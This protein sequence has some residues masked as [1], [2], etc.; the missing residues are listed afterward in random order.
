MLNRNFKI[1]S[2]LINH[3]ADVDALWKP[4]SP[5]SP[6]EEH[7]DVNMLFEYLTSNLDTALVPLRYLLEPLHS[8][9]SVLSFIVVPGEKK[10][11][12]HL[13]CRHGN[14]LIVDYLLKKFNT[15]YHLDFVDCGGF[16]ALH[17]AVFNGH[18]DVARKLYR[19]DTRVDILAGDA[20]L[21]PRG[22]RNALDYCHIL[23]AP[24]ASSLRAS[25]GIIR[26]LE[27]VYLGRLDIAKMLVRERQA[28][29]TV[30]SRDDDGMVWSVKLC[31]YAAQKNMARLLKGSLEN[32]R[33]DV[34][35]SMSR[36]E[37]LD[38]LLVDAALSGHA[39]TTK[40]LVD[41]GANVNQVLPVDRQPTLLHQ[42]VVQADAKM[43]YLLRAGAEVNA[44]DKKGRTPL[45]YA[46]QWKDL[47]TCR[48]LKH[49]GGETT[50]ERNSM[51]RILA[52]IVGTDIG[53][54][55]SLV[56]EQNLHWDV[57]LGGEPSDDDTEGERDDTGGTEGLER[58][59]DE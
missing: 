13:A 25:H 22:R 10:T 38:R 29:R 37:V 30:G 6:D 7:P 48:V 41:H 53:H 17:H 11:A 15:P 21:D 52:N 50:L 31:F 33:D 58:E 3:G 39:G 36:Q 20:S 55:T 9:G 42:A 8:K 19:A 32:L 59:P 49:F 1:A 26:D 34:M 5:N 12:L 16:T 46:L 18:V 24:D 23:F 43:V 14:P 40:A 2:A 54:A 47:A 35:S 27:D 44:Y 28:V 56:Q 57:K 4:V 45:T 51:A